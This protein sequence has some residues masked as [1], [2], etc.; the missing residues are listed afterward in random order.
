MRVDVLKCSKTG[1]R[2]ALRSGQAQG[3]LGG[4]M[5]K[6]VSRRITLFAPLGL[7]LT[8]GG[9]AA[10]EERTAKPAFA[11]TLRPLIEARLK[12]LS[13]PGAMVL[14]EVS[15]Q[16]FWTEAFG[17]SDLR[18]G[19]PMLVQNRMRIGSITKTFTATA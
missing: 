3:G 15:D 14:V 5:H 11:D 16:G 13:I 17:V 18:T 9:C 4:I 8:R 1:R 6:A 12:A 2:P 7:L 19:R 10:A